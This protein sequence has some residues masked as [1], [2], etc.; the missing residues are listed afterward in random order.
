MDMVDSLVHAA[1]VGI[2]GTIILDLYA[3][4]LQRVLDVSGTNWKMVGRWI[5]HMPKGEFIQPAIGQAK[6]VSGEHALGWA[7]HYGIG[8]AYGLLLVAL[9]GTGWL[10]K[11]GITEP[12]ILALALL[13]LPYC[14]MMPGMGMG[15]AGSRTPNPNMTRLKSVVGHC[16]FAAGMYLTARLLT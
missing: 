16:V 5:G 10:Q 11:P 15:M 12:L 1:L 14:V 8:I 2:G 9:W 7:F 6:P 13:M 3:F 4:L